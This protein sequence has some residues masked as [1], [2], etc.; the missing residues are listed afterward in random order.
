[1]RRAYRPKTPED[2]TNGSYVYFLFDVIFKYQATTE[3]P[4]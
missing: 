1:M 2:A 4:R 3:Y